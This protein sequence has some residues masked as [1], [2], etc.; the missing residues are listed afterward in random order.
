[1]R[2]LRR[3]YGPVASKTAALRAG[4]EARNLG[5][6]AGNPGSRAACRGRRISVALGGADGASATALQP[7]PHLL[8]TLPA[9]AGGGRRG[10]L[11]FSA[12]GPRLPLASARGCQTRPPVTL[13]AAVIAGSPVISERVLGGDARLR[14]GG[15]RVSLGPPWVG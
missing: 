8:T 15:V 5:A 12:R 10:S 6:H 3:R 14:R 2:D 9:P 11:R 1:M 7:P 4:L 13:D